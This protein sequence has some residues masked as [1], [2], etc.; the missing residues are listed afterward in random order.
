MSSLKE[1][2]GTIQ[3]KKNQQQK[4]RKEVKNLKSNLMSDEITNIQQS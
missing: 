1:D 3:E 4:L 2:E